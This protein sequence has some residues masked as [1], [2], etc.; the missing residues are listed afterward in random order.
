MKHQRQVRHPG[1]SFGKAKARFLL[2]GLTYLGFISIGLPDGLLGV[3]WPSIRAFFHLPLDALGTLLVMYTTGYLFSSFS[4]GRLLSRISVGS[5]LALSCL[6]TA[7]SL[8]G[9]AL[10]PQWMVMVVCG[11]LS[12]LGAGAIDAGLNTYAATH[13]SARM[14]NWLHACYGIGATSGPIIMTNVMGAHLPWQWG[15]GIVGTGQLVLAACFGLTRTQWPTTSMMQGMT[16]PTPL[17]AASIKST[18]RLPVVWL[19]IAVFFIYTGLEAAT[20]TWTYSLFTEGRAIPM[21]TAGM[22]VS[23][24]WGAL[25][26]GRLVFGLVVNYV[27]VRLF[28]RCC[29]ISIIFGATLLW[30]N[31]TPLFSCLGLAL[32]GLSAAPIFPS[33]IATTPERLG[34]GHTDNG[35]GF[36]IAAAV[37]GQSLLPAIVGVL[38]STLGL[39]IVGTVL[40][41]AALLLLMLYEKLTSTSLQPMQVEK[42]IA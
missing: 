14:V 36:Q 20:G 4:S 9:Y 41:V 7:I 6:A 25:T 31:I 38:A 18:L 27:P 39:E 15:Y 34:E 33:L 42:V 21:S 23:M 2:I 1:E 28:L 40:V 29:I 35:V 11:L 37:L 10:T 30:F 26:V 17:G 19:S 8:L 12:G 13:F 16:I 3:A 32:I 22:W 5:L 24:Y